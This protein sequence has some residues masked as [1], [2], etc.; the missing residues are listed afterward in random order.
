MATCGVSSFGCRSANRPEEDPVARHREEHARRGEHV[1]VGRAGDREEDHRRDDRRANRP[2]GDIHDVRRDPARLGDLGGREDVEVRQVGRDVEQD[3]HGGSDDQA[4]RHV[5]LR[6]PD[7]PGAEADGLPALVRPQRKD[8][9][10]A[11]VADQRAGA[12]TG[13]ARALDPDWPYSRGPR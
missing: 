10:G 8:E 4:E 13:P 12:L 6:V 2:E 11:E 1:A 3:C 7:L 5:A 9:R